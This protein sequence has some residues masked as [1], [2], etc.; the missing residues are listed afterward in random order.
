MHK[1]LRLGL[2]IVVFSGIAVCNSCRNEAHS[3]SF[4]RD[5]MNSVRERAIPS[6]AV[7]DSSSD[8]KLT[9]YSVIADW[10][11]ETSEDKSVYLAWVSRQLQRDFRLKASS[12]SNM[13]FLKNYRGDVES[14][15]IQTTPSNGK[16]HVRVTNSIY[17]D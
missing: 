6:D 5:E 4:V 12:E 13:V 15:S 10:E 2:L 16:L 7:I 3:N 8:P 14:V 9:Q 11:F 1:G 17:P